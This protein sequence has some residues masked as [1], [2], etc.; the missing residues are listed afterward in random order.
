MTYDHRAIEKKWQEEWEQ[1]GEHRVEDG[2]PNPYYALVEFPYPSGDGLHVGHLRSYTAMD[3]ISRKR[4]MEGYSVLFPIGWDAFGLPAENYALKTGQHPRVTTERNIT[5]FRRQLKES[6]FSFDWSREVSTSD[7]AYYRWTQWIFL[8]LLKHGLAYKA[9]M[10]INWCTSCKIGLANEEVV[11]ERCER[12]GGAVEKRDKSQWMLKIT[13]YAEKLLAGLSDVDYIERAALQQQHWIGRRAGATIEFSISGTGERLA[14][15]TTRADTLFG[16]TYVVLAPEHPILETLQDT[17]TNW[18]DVAAYVHAARQK[19]DMVRVAADA[20]KTGVDVQGICAINPVNGEELPVYVADYVLAHY[21][22]GAIMAVPAH[23]QRDWDFAKQFG[24]P[25]RQVICPNYPEPTCPV[26][27]EAYTGEGHLV[28]SGDFTGQPSDS[29]RAAILTSVNG[30]ATVTYKLRDWV[31]SRQRYWG[32]PIPVIH[33]PA[34]GVVAVPE[35]QLPVLLPDVEKYEPTEAGDSPLA[36]VQDWVNTTC[37]SCKGPAQRETDV[38]PNWAGSSWYFLRYCDPKND[39]VLADPAKLSH[40]MP[41]AWYNGGMEH[42]TLHLLYSRF[43]NIFLHDIGIV[44]VSE[45]YAKRTSHGIVLADGGAKMSK[46][47]GNVVNPD[48][49]VAEW[50]ADAVRVYEM[51][52]GPFD[53]AVPWST[54]GIVGVRR[55]LDRVWALFEISGGEAEHDVTRKLHQVIRKVTID[56][57]AMHFNTAVSAMME[58]VNV[59]TKHGSIPTNELQTFIRVLAPFAPHLS[60]ELWQQS[61]GGSASIFS[62]EWPTHDEDLAAEAMST[63]VVQV[64]G[65]VRATLSVSVGLSEKEAT[66]LAMADANVR[67]HLGGQAPKKTI[68]VPEKLVNFVL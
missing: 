65:K 18:D 43:W 46:S 20:E 28:A 55:F 31:F 19:A 22:T 35:D 40:W 44:P 42:T 64:H 52:I 3:I 4:R 13:A 9:T 47:K 62:T 58:F 16:A 17:V 48:A 14:V 36:N 21:G 29:A 7:P 15:F 59:C 32:E 39:R 27:T 5:N 50:G 60:E 51:F 10:P 54:D 26:L 66:T 11:S 38:M 41:V 56:I 34:C 37:P 30:V 24:L 63:L 12:C 45:P 1:R 2:A 25:I 33:C 53:Q 49:L 23:D 57:E 61:G 8:Q 68:F 67:K 6:G